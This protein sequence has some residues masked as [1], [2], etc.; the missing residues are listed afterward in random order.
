M[1]RSRLESCD[2][3]EKLT[4][5]G[6]QERQRLKWISVDAD[7]VPVDFSIPT[8]QELEV[9]LTIVNGGR[10]LIIHFQGLASYRLESFSHSQ[11]SDHAFAVVEALYA[12]LLPF[13]KDHIDLIPRF[14]MKLKAL[15]SVKKERRQ[16]IPTA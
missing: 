16:S 14:P 8:N 2:G 5:G 10:Q 13:H 7:G 4:E 9:E 11:S 3:D 1:F 6:V 15:G 12:V